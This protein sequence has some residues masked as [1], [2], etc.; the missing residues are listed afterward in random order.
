MYCF[1]SSGRGGAIGLLRDRTP[2]DPSKLVE[3][4]RFRE[5][6]TLKVRLVDEFTGKID[7][8]SV[9]DLLSNEKVESWRGIGFHLGFLDVDD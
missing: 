4:L 8:L 1:S 9:R 7:M 6:K 3:Y 2:L 5:H